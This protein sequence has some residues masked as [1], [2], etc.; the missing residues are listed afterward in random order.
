[1][2][3]PSEAP[4][5]SCVPALGRSSLAWSCDLW[6]TLTASPVLQRSVGLGLDL[7]PRPSVKGRWTTKAGKPGGGRQD[8][9]WP[10]CRSPVQA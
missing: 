1:M 4:G 6:G 5:E 3:L 10:R 9:R 8:S 2:P 7:G